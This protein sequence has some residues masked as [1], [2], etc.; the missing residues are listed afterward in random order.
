MTRIQT[1]FDEECDVEEIILRL[2]L[3]NDF[4][5][6]FWKVLQFLAKTIICFDKYYLLFFRNL[7]KKIFLDILK[8]VQPAKL[9]LPLWGICYS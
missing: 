9:A 8:F 7:L 3:M 2:C 4:V 5:S 1:I 6:L